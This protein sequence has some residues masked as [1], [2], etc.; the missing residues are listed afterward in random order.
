MHLTIGRKL[1]YDTAARRRYNDIWQYI[2]IKKIILLYN[3]T[4]NPPPYPTHTNTN[5]RG[6]HPPTPWALYN[7]WTAPK[8]N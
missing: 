1:K 5:T 7:M 6:T 2:N 8:Y 4:F 3:K